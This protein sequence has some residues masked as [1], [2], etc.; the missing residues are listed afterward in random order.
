MKT[1]RRVKLY[2]YSFFDLGARWGWLVN[3]NGKDQVPIAQE[4]G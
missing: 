1:R 4:A 2:L 3:A